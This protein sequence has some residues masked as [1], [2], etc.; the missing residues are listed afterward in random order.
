MTK[1]GLVVRR[2]V[3]LPKG[4]RRERKINEKNRRDYRRESS[5]VNEPP[6][7]AKVKTSLSR[8]VTLRAVVGVEPR[9]N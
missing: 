6:R 4:K 7:A 1:P 3:D 9:S 5:L 8:A 2:V